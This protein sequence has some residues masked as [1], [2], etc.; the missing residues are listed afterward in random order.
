LKWAAKRCCH[1]QCLLGHSCTALHSHLVLVVNLPCIGSTSIGMC[2]RQ[3]CLSEDKRKVPGTIASKRERKQG[4]LVL[5]H[6]ESQAPLVFLLPTAQRT[7]DE[8][9]I[10]P[11]RATWLGRMPTSRAHRDRSTAPM[12]ISFERAGTA[13][14][15]SLHEST[16]RTQHGRF[17]SQREWPYSITSALK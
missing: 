15:P 10:Q 17:P 5:Q 7:R 12:H 8:M 1:D 4:S 9:G 13:L 14:P 2:G 6:V 11:T 3:Q 16:S